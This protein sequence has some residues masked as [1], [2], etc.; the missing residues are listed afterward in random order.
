LTA[1]SLSV[2]TANPGP[3]LPA[4]AR[5]LVA[6]ALLVPQVIAGIYRGLGAEHPAGLALLGTALL[7]LGVIVWFRSYCR[8]FRISQPMDMGWFLMIAWPVIVPYF[9]LRHEGRRG[10][11]RIG[12]FILGWLVAALIGVLVGLTVASIT[13]DL[14]RSE[15]Q[16]STRAA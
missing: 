8:A 9:I 2:A 3:K 16:E 14:E 12:Y 15:D 11:R 7:V 5:R 10:L 6:V 1:T 13:G 4:A